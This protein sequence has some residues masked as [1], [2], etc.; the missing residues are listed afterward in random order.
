MLAS[1]RLLLIAAL[2]VGCARV[3]VRESRSLETAPAFALASHTGGTISLEQLRPH[4]VMAVFYR[5]F[6]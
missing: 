6:W 5:G 1:C 4:R 3:E 2:L